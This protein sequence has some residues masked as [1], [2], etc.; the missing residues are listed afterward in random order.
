MNSKGI[1]FTASV[2]LLISLFLISYTFYSIVQDRKPVQDRIE[3]MNNFLFSIEEDLPRQLYISGFRAIF[4][5]QSEILQT[6]LY[7]DDV[8]SSFQEIFYQGTYN[9]QEKEIM[10]G[11]TFSD[12]LKSLQDMGN[13]VNINVT[14]D[15]QEVFISQSDPWE[16]NVT[17]LADLHATD[18]SNLASWNREIIIETSI[19]IENL[20]DP[21]YTVNTNGLV[22]T[23]ILKA[24]YTEFNNSS[25]LDHATNSF[26][27]ANPDAPSFLNRLEG[28]LSPDANGIESLVNLQKLS[29][30]G[31]LARDKSIVDHIY[32]SDDNPAAQV[33]DGMPSWFKLDEQHREFYSV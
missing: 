27:I 2:L 11:A 21:L 3:T 5:F 33:V 7:V 12:I 26:Y 13:R 8:N 22:T 4:I 15:N 14:L 25:L 23:K 16:I 28:D 30:Q 32:F 19:P 9:G 31:I 20:T 6:G 29:Q 18:K 24:P 1:F 10:I 17:L